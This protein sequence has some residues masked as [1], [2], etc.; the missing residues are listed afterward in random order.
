ML[1][2]RVHAVAWFFRSMCERLFDFLEGVSLSYE[3]N[4]ELQ[5]NTYT[6]LPGMCVALLL[7]AVGCG[8]D[9]LDHDAVVGE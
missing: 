6:V 7:V 1:V 3:V 8:L 5:Y 2:E 4:V 9:E